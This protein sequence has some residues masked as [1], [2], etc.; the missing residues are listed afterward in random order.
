M[1]IK[2]N[3]RIAL[4]FLQCW[5]AGNTSVVDELAGPDFTVL[6]NSWPNKVHGAEAFKRILEQTFTYFPDMQIQANEVIA[7]GDKVVIHWTYQGTHQG[8]DL[9]G[10][11]ASGKRVQVSGFTIYRLAS[12]KVVEETGMVDTHSLMAQIN[13]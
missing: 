8:G 9:E 3:K 5:T 11:E 13:S 2:E 10:E 6:Y 7:E 12:G 4:Q 1:T